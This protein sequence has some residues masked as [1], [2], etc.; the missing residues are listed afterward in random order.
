MYRFEWKLW[1]VATGTWHG[2]CNRCWYM[3]RALKT[4]ETIGNCQRPVF[5]LGVAQHLHKITNLWKFEVNRSSKLRD[6]NERK[7]PLS[8]EVVCFHMADFET[9]NSKSE[10]SKSNSLKN[11]SFPKN[12]VTLEGAVSNNVFYYQQLPITRYQ[13]RFYYNNNNYFE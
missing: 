10:V 9:S 7:I 8:H 5:S 12:Y 11:T 1:A 6:N 13:V 2:S 4:L 3:Y